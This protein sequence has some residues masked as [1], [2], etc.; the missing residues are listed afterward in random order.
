MK[1][2]RD[3]AHCKYESYTKDEIDTKLGNKVDTTEVY[4]KGNF[5][6]LEKEIVT[7]T[8]N[9]SIGYDVVD[10]PEGFNKD[11]T[12]IISHKVIGGESYIVSYVTQFGADPINYTSA[13]T[14][15]LNE[16]N[17][18]LS[19]RLPTFEIGTKVK[20]QFLLMKVE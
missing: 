19:G 18:I 15:Y 3:K 12:Y 1:F 10:Y 16:D 14:C 11:N 4:T 20:I 7:E 13:I 8:E 2:L 5:A 17:M 6:I 9:Q